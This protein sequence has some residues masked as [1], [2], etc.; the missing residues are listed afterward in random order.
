MRERKRGPILTW[1]D[2]LTL[3]ALVG[4]GVGL[5]LVPA[6]GGTADTVSI[7][8]A[9]GFALEVRLAEDGRY[10]VPGPLGQTVIVVRAGAAQVESSPCPHQIC[11]GMRAVDRPGETVVCVPNGVVVRVLGGSLHATTR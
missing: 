9:G 11:V 3:Y 8:G 4:A 6:A 5:L 2:R 1:A 7:T 10:E